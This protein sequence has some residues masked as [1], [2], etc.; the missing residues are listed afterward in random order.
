MKRKN[1][2]TQSVQLN[3]AGKSAPVEYSP[4]A[5]K[6]I[7]TLGKARHKDRNRL[8]LGDNKDVTASLLKDGF[9]GKIK[10]I[11]IDPPFGIG[12]DR[13]IE[14]GDG[15]DERKA[16]DDSWGKNLDAYI[17]MMYERLVLMKDLLAA[18]GS[19]YVHLDY[20]TSH[21]IK[22]IMDELFGRDNLVNQIIWQRTGAHNDPQAFGRNHDI[23]LFYQKSAKR[24]W[25][26]PLV[27]YDEAHLKRYF[28]QD[29]VGRWFR[30]NNPTGKGYQDHTRD[31]GK[32]PVKPPRDRHWSVTQTQID[33]W[34]AE[35]R[36]VFTSSGYPFV[37]KYLDE[38]SGKPVQS[39]WTD[40][41]PPRSSRELTGF[42]TQKPE[43]LLE[44]IIEAS[45]NPGDLVADF[46]CGS[47]TT[48]VVAEKLG[49][50]WLGCDSSEVAI[51]I[52]KER[53]LKM[54]GGKVFEVLD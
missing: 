17:R 40:L 46:F 5:F 1:D 38:M 48:L 8:Y 26:K 53:L 18:D 47:G 12:N 25:N 30:L 44:R 27:D 35:N 39:I 52:A 16:Y 19:I 6:L 42:P 41:I 22:I 20:H 45:S 49:R 24:V 50:R 29:A 43:K 2:D 23:I 33:K 4:K 10:L 51:K 36:I 15:I 9:A 14:A 13:H 11:Y 28:Q 31:F 3:W 7:E 54:N 32:G 21:Y 37:K 34:L